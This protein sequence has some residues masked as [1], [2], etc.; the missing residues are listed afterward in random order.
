MWREN[1][2]T[3]PRTRGPPGTQGPGLRCTVAIKIQLYRLSVPMLRT[4][5]LTV[6][7]VLYVVAMHTVRIVI[8]AVDAILTRLCYFTLVYL[9]FTLQTQE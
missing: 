6:S 1:V 7:N 4:H 8:H 9:I 5:K 3:G 2:N